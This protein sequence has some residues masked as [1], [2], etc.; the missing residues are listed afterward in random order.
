[1]TEQETTYII[2]LAAAAASKIAR[3]P[4]RK[5]CFDKSFKL[6]NWKI[7]DINPIYADTIKH[8]YE[9]AVHAQRKVFP[10]ELLITKAP[11]QTEA[12]WNYQCGLY[13]S[14]TRSV[15]G[16]ALNKTKIIANKQNYSITG[17]DAEQQK[18]FYQDYP[19]YHSVESYFFDI[20]REEKINYP[21]KLLVIEPLDI[22]MKS[23][24]D[25]LPVPDDSKM[26][27][28]VSRIIEEQNIM[29]YVENQFTMIYTGK[30][31]LKSGAEYPVFKIYDKDRIYECSVKATDEKGKAIYSLD[32]IYTHN[33]GYVPCRKLGGKPSVVDGDVFN[34]SYFSDAIPDLNGVIR[35]KS[36]LD[37]AYM[38]NV[39]P[40]R[41]ERESD[42]THSEGNRSCSGGTIWRP[43]ADGITGEH[44][45]CPSCKGTG[46]RS[47]YSPTSVYVVS[48][49][50]KGIP[51]DRL[52]LD[53]VVSF[54]SPP[55]EALKLLKDHIDDQRE[56]AFSF[57]F[58]SAE[59]VQQTAEGSHLEKEEF[60]AF[61]LQLSSE[62]F[63]LME[64]DIEAKGW[65]RWGD[66]FV[67][68]T[69]S[70]PT[71]F[72]FRT[73][74]DITAEISEAVKSEM[75]DPYVYVLLLELASTR[76]N[77]NPDAVSFIK[78]CMNVNTLWS[79][80][81][82]ELIPFRNQTV[83]NAD[84]VVKQRVTSLV[85]KAFDE[86]D[87]FDKMSP[88]EQREE[89]YKYAEDILSLIPKQQSQFAADTMG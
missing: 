57:L 50:S 25:G 36:N 10:Y 60:H 16:R 42:C 9:V 53:E 19:L 22:P 24:E 6:D 68:P 45:Q 59:K 48:D 79:G 86:I 88:E 30:R 35:L 70:R 75:P 62:L 21:N 67:K 73:P 39:F 20:V 83:T 74:A 69:I 51:S 26:I 52:P 76:F 40:V 47:H 13:E 82:T 58:K 2:D 31:K 84:I 87:D 8:H 12:E 85:R 81:D 17:W 77:S 3:V 15:W 4:V 65:Y 55:S 37:M 54:A 27:E 43:S 29:H 7:P 46:R 49:K 38:A 32:L 78:S 71:S 34:E 64:F 23:G 61:L 44:V 41:I 11:N 18:Y 56:D 28:P 1:M 89:I 80:T 33:W 5:D 14:Y 66:K 72:S 63:D